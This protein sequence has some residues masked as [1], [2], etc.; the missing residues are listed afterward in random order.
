MAKHDNDLANS[1]FSEAGVWT[2]MP[3][4]DGQRL[5]FSRADKTARVEL[6][7]HGSGNHSRRAILNRL[8]HNLLKNKNI[9]E[10]VPW[11][12]YW[13]PMGGKPKRIETGLPSSA[14]ECN[15]SVFKD[16]KG[17]HVSF[18]GGIWNKDRLWYRLYAATGETLETLGQF[19]PVFNHYCWSGFVAPGYIATVQ[20]HRIQIHSNNDKLT[21]N[22][23]F[24]RIYRVIFR[25][26]RPR[27]L[28]M[29]CGNLND[30]ITTVQYD[31]DT[32]SIDEITS[33]QVPYKATIF[34]DE[35]I[36]SSRLANNANS[37]V[38]GRSQRYPSVRE[39]RFLR[40]TTASLQRREDIAI[41]LSSD[42]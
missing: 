6:K 12:L 41:R 17:W 35:L 18:V 5:F 22:V 34:G 4:Y 20:N 14:V 19:K 8:K 21:L 11:K 10:Y 29:T 15:A 3:F 42:A 2:H 32:K 39:A 40:K 37:E 36:Y 25:A 31:L 23:P 26:D 28:V 38:E 1:L 16:S 13:M 30:Q 27:V 33:D 7:R 9:V 24:K